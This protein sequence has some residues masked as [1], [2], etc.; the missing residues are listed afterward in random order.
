M[1]NRLGV[2]ARG[3]GD[4]DDDDDEVE[5]VIERAKGI[6]LINCSMTQGT[7]LLM[8]M[9]TD[10]MRKQILISTIKRQHEIKTG[11]NLISV[12]GPN[13]HISSEK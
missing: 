13:V 9:K 6:L 4:D 2:K 7:V 11:H 12:P 5:T 10:A 1:R 8:P 3:A